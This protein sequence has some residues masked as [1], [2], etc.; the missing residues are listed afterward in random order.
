MKRFISLLLAVITAFS[1]FSMLSANAAFSDVAS[2]AYCKEAVEALVGLGILKGY[3]DGT[4]GPERNVTRAEMATVIVRA[5]GLESEAKNSMNA[6]K[7]DD[8]DGGHWASGYV[9]VAVNKGIIKGDGNGKFRP[10]DPVRH[11]E[12]IKMVVCA[13]GFGEG[14]TSSGADWAKPYIDI[15]SAKGISNGLLSSKGE[16][17]SRGDVAVMVYNGL[18]CD[19]E[20]PIFSVRGG[21]YNG[22]RRVSV[23][24]NTSDAKIYYTTDGSK[25]SKYSTPYSGPVDILSS[26]VLRAVTVKRGM[27]ESEETQ[28]SY[29]IEYNLFGNTG[30]YNVSFDLN[31]P[32]SA[33]MRV[34]AAQKVKRGKNVVM[35]PEPVR[36]GYYFAG[37]AYDAEGTDMFDFTMAIYGDTKL[38]AVWTTET[39]P[40]TVSFNLNCSELIYPPANQT[41]SFG[42]KAVAPQSPQRDGYAFLGGSV[43]SK[44]AS[45]YNFNNPVKTNMTLYAKWA[46]RTGDGPVSLD[47]ERKETEI[48]SFDADIR[49]ILLGETKT[50]N[51]T[52]EIFSSIPLAADDVKLVDENGSLV[53]I[54]NDKGEAGD[55]CAND[56]IYTLQKEFYA[57]EIKNTL[58]YVVCRSEK[59]DS[60]NIGFYRNYTEKDYNAMLSVSGA[61]TDIVNASKEIGVSDVTEETVNAVAK[62]VEELKN[63]GDVKDYTIGENSVTMTLKDGLPVIYKLSS[64]DEYD[65][66]SGE[67]NIMTFEPYKG[68]LSTPE[69]NADMDNASDGD[70]E[71]IALRDTHFKFT[72]NYDLA[73]VTLDKIH[74]I[75][76][77]GIMIW[78]GHGLYDER[79]GSSLCTG[80]VV[81]VMSLYTYSYLLANGSVTAIADPNG[82]RLGITGGYVKNELKDLNG[83]LIYLIACHSGQDMVDNI[84][85]GYP[86][87]KAFIDNGAAAVVGTTGAVKCNYSHKFTMALFDRL[88]TISEGEYFTL[89]EA[90]AYAKSVVGATDANNT[91]F[92]IFPQESAVANNF[93][94]SAEYGGMDGS[95]RDSLTNAP[96]PNALVRIYL[97]GAL[98]DSTRTD[99]EGYS[100]V[101]DIPDGEYIVQVD[102]GGYRSA[103]Y[104]IRINEG[105]TTHSETTFMVGVEMQKGSAKGTIVNS[106]TGLP[107]DGVE[108]TFRKSWNNRFGSTVF[109]ASTDANGNY[110]V[111]GESGQYTMEFAKDGYITGYKNVVLAAGE[112]SSAQNDAITPKLQNSSSFRITL[113][114][115][116]RPSD[117]DAH[118]TGPT[119]NEG[120]RFHLYHSSTAAN[121]VNPDKYT[122][123]LDNRD[124]TENINP[125]TITVHKP[126]DGVYRFVVDNFSLESEDTDLAASNATV[127]I[128]YG[129]SDIVVA[130]YDVPTSAVATVWV[131]CDIEVVDGLIMPPKKINRTG[132][133]LN[134]ELHN[135]D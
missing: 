129:N 56:G 107:V 59:S 98:V 97:D 95:I 31:C 114:W 50:V 120:E 2:D 130:S 42:G 44:G 6:T 109:T 20:K 75:S 24:T 9:N 91:E 26:C 3:D 13:E 112:N 46:A 108:L 71:L 4:F 48:F 41:V 72:G 69:L 132:F 80:E 88:T 77:A 135:I 38:Y 89:S 111:E 115:R 117:L 19:L 128:Y 99:D 70:A 119:G 67:I 18:K 131:V 74:E 1:S 92:M 17:A 33:D 102:A 22:P 30:T 43:A 93:R 51:F 11:E 55:A 28:A 100:I 78:I 85:S 82:M 66:A 39:G 113:T 52:A 35:P 94:L 64:D 12:A 63:S 76:K 34:P 125:E 36:D 105:E 54:M 87:A 104:S 65:G 96:I 90:L 45:L 15:A 83:S 86:L 110:S 14:I 40:Y 121:H 27:L 5:L 84:D 134:G 122:L 23:T 8:I 118:L 116:D 123:D 103:K 37:W 16:L 32:H 53:G 57:N 60:L 124:I 21:E 58:Y 47:D 106:Q 7:F 25:P 73:D 126:C 81:S 133:D 127:N 10:S 68:T 49:D 62:K 61:L 101:T 79:L 29:V